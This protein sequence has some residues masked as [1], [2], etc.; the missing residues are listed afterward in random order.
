M[1]KYKGYAANTS[2]SK[3]IN[4]DYYIINYLAKDGNQR[5][6][7][8]WGISTETL[9]MYRMREERISTQGPSSYE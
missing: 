1:A 2:K 7:D 4:K 6:I 5:H 8:F 3:N 9:K